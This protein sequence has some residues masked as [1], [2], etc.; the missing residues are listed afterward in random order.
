MRREYNMDYNEYQYTNITSATTT[1]VATGKG[2]L[3]AIVVN[4]TAAGTI[5]I[6][7]NTTGTTANI[8]TLKASVAENTYFYD[9]YFA[10][11]LRIVTAG[12]SDIT[13]IWKQA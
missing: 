13:V 7:D 12:A 2:K 4:T 10:K 9:C 11:G 8:G 3:H 5:K 1:Q 6:I